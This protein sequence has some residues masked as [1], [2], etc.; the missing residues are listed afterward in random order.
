MNITDY[1]LIVVGAGLSGMVIAEQFSSKQNKRSLIID[2][3]DH[4]GGNCYDYIDKDTGILMNKYG[5][6]LFHTNHEDVFDYI[7]QFCKWSPWEH[8]VLGLI[9]D[10]HLPIPPNITTVNEIFN[11]N[12][13][14]QEEMEQWLSENQV[15]YDE[16]T[17]GEE[18]AKSRVGEV[19]Y[20]KIFKHYTFK[21]WKKYPEELAPEVLARIP[22]RNSFDDR[23]FSDKYQVLPEKGYTAFFQGIL[24]KHKDN[25]DVK[26]NMD[27]FDIKDKITKNQLVIYTGPIDAYFADKGLPKLEYRSIDFHIERKMNTDYYQP[28]SVVNYPGKE[29]RFTRC[30][31]YKH[32]LNQKSD[33]TVY[34]KE[35]TTD[36]GEPYYPVL[37]DRNK[38]LYAKYQKMAGEEGENIHFIGRLASYKYF[39]MDQAIKNSLDYYKNHFEEKKK[40][41]IIISRYN[42]DITWVDKIKDNNLIKHIIIFNKG[43]D[44][45]FTTSNKVT[46]LQVK[47]IGREGGTY[48]DY[49]INN[50]YNLPE[51][52]I[53][54][55]ADPLEHN[56]DIMD[57]FESKNIPLYIDKDFVTLTK[58]WKESEDIPPRK[59][60]NHNNSY[61]IKN[62]ELIKYFVRDYDQQV[63]A[64]SSFYDYFV[65]RKYETYFKNFYNSDNI[66]ECLCDLIGIEKSKKI[67]PICWS[68][69]FFVKSKQIM[70]HPIEVYIKLRKFLYNSND[71]GGEEGYFLE[72]FWY[73]LFTGES[74][75]TI[76]ECLQE[77]FESCDN[78]I[79]IYNSKDYTLTF[80][81]INDCNNVIESDNSYILYNVDGKQKVLPGVTFNGPNL[82]TYN[83][84]I[85]INTAMLIEK[86][87]PLISVIITTYNVEM[88]IEQAIKSVLNQTYKNLEIII[89]DDCSSDNTQ[90]II[91]KYEKINNNIIFKKLDQ[92]TGGGC[93]YTSNIGLSMAKGE[94]I[95]FLD[96]DD[97]IHN[98]MV[99][100]LFNEINSKN[101][102]LVVCN[103]YEDVNG[104]IRNA[105]HENIYNKLL[106]KYNK[107]TLL[108]ICPGPWSKIYRRSFVKENDIKF[109]EGDYFYEDNPFHWLNII[110]TDKIGVIPDKLIYHRQETSR[111]QTT[112]AFN[113]KDNFDLTHLFSVFYAIKN[114]IKNNNYYKN[115]FQQWCK[116]EFLKSIVKDDKKINNKINRIYNNFT[117]NQSTYVYDISVIIY[118]DTK[119]DNSNID[120]IITNDNNIEI[121]IVND[122]I[123]NNRLSKYNRYD[124]VFIINNKSI[125]GKNKSF[126]KAIP[127]IEGKYSYFLNASDKKKLKTNDIDNFLKNNNNKGFTR[128]SIIHNNTEHFEQEAKPEFEL[129]SEKIN[130][131]TINHYKRLLQDI[132]LESESKPEANMKNSTITKP[133]MSTITKFQSILNGYNEKLINKKKEVESK[134]ADNKAVKIITELYETIFLRV[135]DDGGLEYWVQHYNNG[136]SKEA[137]KNVMMNSK[138]AKLLKKNTSK[139][140]NHKNK[141]QLAPQ[142]AFTRKW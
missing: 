80:K 101:L 138:E 1:D 117:N 142:F 119:A 127:I 52:L 17:N 108:Q 82:F 31:E 70:R 40:V 112:S 140:A 118:I 65:D 42:E 94:Y 104:N 14:N 38:E 95:C 63:T 32:F 53:F 126:N 106:S 19:L 81:K 6:H 125:L 66:T 116:K 79:K 132:K 129:K 44:N 7:N 23:Y 35:T 89:V 131:I 12:I 10:K 98:N 58:Q 121:I 45:I 83:N 20:E 137:I 122:D 13:K 73:Y 8:K 105:Y 72:R 103:Y 123:T 30:V 57:F 25:I 87:Y 54:T 60:V 4:I 28:Y 27:F 41:T 55:Q 107:S 43:K 69:C 85:N 113:T 2:K 49:I 96:G 84:I 115:T 102:D 86:Y 128:S 11:L 50:Y 141:N 36:K 16:I 77:L 110:S 56:K 5:A 124:S 3:R 33:H 93:C 61:N 18:M 88:Y 9:D 46:I 134:C 114:L 22:V 62:L 92:R 59:F 15:K 136:M 21:Q 130:D 68:A 135:P 109:I 133:K 120:S 100:K 26:L 76:D 75:N 78:V 48:L 51:N 67:I 71:Q 111:K 139:L 37:N 90:E 34:V 64:H 99:Q 97:Y 29:T 47:N 74:Y 91:S 24:D 39:N